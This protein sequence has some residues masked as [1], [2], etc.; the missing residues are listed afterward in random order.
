MFPSYV[1]REDTIT[2][3]SQ[4]EGKGGTELAACML[5]LM[6]TMNIYPHILQEAE[7]DDDDFFTYY[8]PTI[9]LF[10]SCMYPCCLLCFFFLILV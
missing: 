9:N 10:I 5:R 2:E 8:L 4:V 7:I 3:I 1:S 6:L